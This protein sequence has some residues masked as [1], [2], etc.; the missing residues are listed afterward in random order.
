M[1]AGGLAQMLR[2]WR[3][4]LDHHHQHST[5][6]PVYQLPVQLLIQS[7]TA[8]TPD[9]VMLS[10]MKKDKVNTTTTTSGNQYRFIQGG[11]RS[12]NLFDIGNPTDG[13]IYPSTSLG[14]TK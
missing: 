8:E 11:T 6:L 13:T 10:A 14:A 5:C 3:S 1:S 7:L 12:L 4:I 9:V 2:Y